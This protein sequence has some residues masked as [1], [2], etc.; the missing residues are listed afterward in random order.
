[1][2]DSIRSATGVHLANDGRLGYTS[3]RKVLENIVTYTEKELS[4]D[5]M[6]LLLKYGFSFDVALQSDGSVQLVD[7]N[8][9]G[10][11]SGCGACL[12]NWVLDGKVMY[13]L[14]EPQFTVTVY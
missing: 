3:A 6:G 1:V 14:E 11:M 9:F 4:K 13:G 5:M 8:P 2:A 7:I 12:F 10:A